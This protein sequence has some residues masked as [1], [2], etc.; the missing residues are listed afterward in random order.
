MWHF[1]AFPSLP[2]SFGRMSSL[3][4]ALIGNGSIGALIDGEARVAWCCFPRFDGDPVFCSLLD[5]EPRPDQLG[6]FSI[7]LTGVTRRE[8]R[9][10]K[11]TP[12]LVTRLYDA[13]GGGVEI[14]DFCPRFEDQGEMFAPAMLVR[15][16]R[17]IGGKPRMAGRGTH[18]AHYGCVE[19]DH[20]IG[21]NHIHSSGGQA[22]RL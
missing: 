7:E 6:T 12:V 22:A 18:A 10:L 4:L 16:I 14:T 15:Q 19:R 3:D 9:Y 11:D 21:P 13:K 17:P 8:Q 20:A 2:A 1:R 5:G